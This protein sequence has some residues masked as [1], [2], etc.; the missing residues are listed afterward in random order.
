MSREIDFDKVHAAMKGHDRPNGSHW[1][2]PSEWGRLIQKQL[3]ETHGQVSEATAI[4]RAR[5][6]ANLIEAT[7]KGERE[8]IA[9]WLESQGLVA[10]AAEVRKMGGTR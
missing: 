3:E 2:N 5:L 8:R 6:L 7:R 10:R 1:S 9:S 4:E